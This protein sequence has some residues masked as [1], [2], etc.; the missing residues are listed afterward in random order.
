M[1]KQTDLINVTDAITV[2][3]SNVGI[4]TSSPSAKLEVAGNV[5]LGA[6]NPMQTAT[7]VVHGTSGQNGFSIRTAVS[8]ATTP[9]Y[10]NV[11]D[12]NTGM[13]FPVA[14][15]LG[16]TTGGTERMRID[17]SGNAIFTK[18]GGAYLQLKDA[19]AIRGSINV[20][21]SDGLIFTTGSSFTERMRIDSSGNVLIGTTNANIYSTTTTGINLNPDGPTSFNRNGGQAAMFNRI[22]SDG[23]IV[24]FR[25]DGTLV[26][27]IQSRAGA[28]ATII[29]DPRGNGS[30]LT[31]TTNGIIPTTQTGSPANNHVDL[32]TSSSNFRN[33]YLSGGIYLGGT[34][35]ANKLDDYEEGTWTPTPYQGSISFGGAW[36]IKV[37]NLV[38]VYA[39]IY[40]LSDTTTS[41]GVGIKD[42]PFTAHSSSN[43]VGTM[44]G[45]SISSS[46]GYNC[47]VSANEAAVYFYEAPEASNTYETMKHN[48]LT[49][50][51]DF[52]FCITY[53]AS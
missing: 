7:N 26:G 15:T 19:S 44:I 48:D 29:L 13:F 41:N 28:V 23:D 33:A 31:G 51:S 14:D 5:K 25:K 6:V 32:G 16:I 18:S 34:G 47:Y 3:G 43:S 52:H 1:S 49:S 37:G 12:P 20:T 46:I 39:N 45:K 2:S 11:D 38:T 8:G 22:N 42:L 21:T 4:G 50:S 30:G 24:Q 17:S 35:S 36:Y 10:S 40:N 53:R 9:T 27:S